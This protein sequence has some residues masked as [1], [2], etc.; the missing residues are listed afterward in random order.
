VRLQAIFD[1]NIFGDIQDG[2]ISARDWRFLLKH[3]P[4]H[5]WPLSI[6]TAAELLAG[7]PDVSPE[8]F[9]KAKG[10]IELAC[11]ISK[12]RIPLEEP[13]FLLCKEVLGIPFP[14][15]LERLPP[16]LVADHMKVVRCAKSAIDIRKGRVPVPRL[17]TKGYGHKGFAGFDA[18]VIAELLGGDGS[19]KKE[20][21]QR[22][23]TFASDIYPEWR[24]HFKATGQRLPDALRSTIE[25]VSVWYGERERFPE[26]ILEWL[27]T[28]PTPDLLAKVAKRLDAVFEF[29][30][31]VDREFLLR[32]YNPEKHDSD[33]YDQFQLRYLAMDR[34]VIVTQDADLFT[35]TARSSQA[36]RI[37]SLDKFLRSL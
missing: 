18:S 22:L 35:R 19:P 11:K 3:R 34:F 9:R 28:S 32:R 2:T 10:Q 20:W 4:G 17:L 27:E 33:V 30:L 23:E 16:E 5:G 14:E 8:Q 25:S 37:Q 13:R 6:V 12:G 7:L 1:T 29:T 26:T 24:E 31:F 15:K 36:E 21:V